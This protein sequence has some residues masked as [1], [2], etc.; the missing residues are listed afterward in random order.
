MT[1]LMM[2]GAQADELIRERR[3]RGLD[4]YDEVWKG[5]YQVAPAGTS[6]HGRFQA[7]LIAVLTEAAGDRY[8][9]TGPVNIG[10]PMDYRVP[11]CAMVPAHV[12]DD[13]AVWLGSAALVGEVV[14]P[15]DTYADKF[16]H[17][18]DALVEEVIVVDPAD[19]SVEIWVR[20]DGKVQ[21]LYT[22][23]SRSDVTGLHVADFVQRLGL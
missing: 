12:H 9:V 21:G 18:W 8:V 4:T 6:A 5:V 16:D 7:R 15:S 1:E 3:E 17:Y 10:H 13:D 11:D 14:S 19:R 2:R 20:D 22:E 23:A